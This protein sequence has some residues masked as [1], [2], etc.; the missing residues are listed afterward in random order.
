MPNTRR[1]ERWPDPIPL[2]WPTGFAAVT[3]KSATTLHAVKL[4]D[5]WTD[6]PHT[7]LCCLLGPDRYEL[8]ELGH[9]PR[10]VC[11]ICSA[12]LERAMLAELELS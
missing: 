7:T 8:V 4:G 3:T 9:E 5:R 12:E 10:R 2:T 1:G 6:D 11:R